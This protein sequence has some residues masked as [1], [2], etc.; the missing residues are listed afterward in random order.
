MTSA[1]VYSVFF[2]FYLSKR[3][4]P[5]ILF[6]NT[7]HLVSL[8][9]LYDTLR[10]P[11]YYYSVVPLSVLFIKAL[12]IAF[13]SANGLAQLIVLIIIEIGSLGTTVILRPYQTRGGDVLSNT[14]ASGRILATG[15]SFAFVERFN[16]GAITR[17]VV[18][19]VMALIFSLCVVLMFFNLL[20][21]LGLRSLWREH[22]KRRLGVRLG[23]NLF[24][25]VAREK[26]KGVPGYQND[27]ESS[28][29]SLSKEKGNPSEFASPTRSDSELAERPRNPTP[30]QNVPLDP[31]LNEPY[32]ANTPTSAG[33][34][35]V[36]R[37]DSY[38]SSQMPSTGTTLDSFGPSSIGSSTLGT[39]LPRRESFAG[40]GLDQ[41]DLGEG[42]YQSSSR[43]VSVPSTPAS[44]NS[45][46][47]SGTGNR[48]ESWTP[49]PALHKMSETGERT[50]ERRIQM[51]V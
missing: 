4:H 6:N 50:D 33:H 32:P 49:N 37:H 20:T 39:E 8:G 41:I 27:V 7:R 12:V 46:R 38:H 2:I 16:I 3:E 22:V 10:L 40:L 26:N 42:G 21:N 30:Q 48:R 13:G 45:H 35:S 11:R 9:P 23:S 14:L 43:S 1:L 29:G 44:F 15:L 31:S 47:Q 28:N 5:E 25:G 18:G 19:I 36:F 34:S 51:A 17:V 24:L